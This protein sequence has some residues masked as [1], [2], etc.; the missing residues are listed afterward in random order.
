M[1]DWTKQRARVA[2]L[3]RH[4][5]QD[6]PSVAEARRDLKAERLAEQVERALADA[7]PLSE[8]QR[9]RIAAL[10]TASAA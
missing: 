2:A 4:H 8:S 7:P 9:R 3:S 6:H 1:S 5:S 10:L